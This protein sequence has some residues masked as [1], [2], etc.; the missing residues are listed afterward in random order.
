MSKVVAGA[1]LSIRAIA[2]PSGWGHPLLFAIISYCGYAISAACLGVA[3]VQAVRYLSRPQHAGQEP[4][5]QPG[6]AMS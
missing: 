3:V 6:R 5:Q 1:G 4:G 2:S